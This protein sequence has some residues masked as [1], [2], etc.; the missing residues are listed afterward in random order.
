VA[1]DGGG[2]FTEWRV[3]CVLH[4]QVNGKVSQL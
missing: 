4:C 3:A 2:G 1:M